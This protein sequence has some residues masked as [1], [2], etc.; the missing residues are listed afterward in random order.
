MRQTTMEMGLSLGK[1]F[2]ISLPGQQL[3][4][5]CKAM[6]RAGRHLKPAM[7]QLLREALSHVPRMCLLS[8]GGC[9]E[10]RFCPRAH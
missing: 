6:T 9:R 5:S 4:M 1:S 3:L 2:M 10:E 7:V 8:H